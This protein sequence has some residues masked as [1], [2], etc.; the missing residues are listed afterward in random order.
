MSYQFIS[1]N[2]ILLYIEQQK[3]QVNYLLL[4]NNKKKDMKSIAWQNQLYNREKKKRKK[5]NLL[6]RDWFDLNKRNITNMK[7]IS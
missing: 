6:N 1:K 2:L 3:I 4:E 7:Q 5:F